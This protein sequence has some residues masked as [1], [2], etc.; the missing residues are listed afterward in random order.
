M[1]GLAR[2]AGHARRCRA[3]Q[4][5]PGRQGTPGL[6]GRS[7]VTAPAPADAGAYPRAGIGP[8]LAEHPAD[9][10]A[11][12]SAWTTD[13]RRGPRR[14]RARRLR[15]DRRRP[16]QRLRVRSRRSTGCPSS[17]ASAS[18]AW[19]SGALR[20][21][22]MS[23]QRRLGAVRCQAVQA[24]QRRRGDV[25]IGSSGHALRLGRAGPPGGRGGAG[26]RDRA[27]PRRR[28]RPGAGA[29]AGP[30]AGGR[31]VRP[32]WDRRRARASCRRNCPDDR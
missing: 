2:D 21:P 24:V 23:R 8:V 16:G 1:N 12:E 31:L 9:G 25:T 28:A 32:T 7:E 17:T 27:A 14:S 19:P 29:D 26:P 11:D 6:L 4:A 20:R 13:G 18:R 5:M 30:A 15:R 10:P 3:R 22:R